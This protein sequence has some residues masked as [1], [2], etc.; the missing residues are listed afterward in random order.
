MIKF[1]WRPLIPGEPDAELIWGSILGV[2]AL[3]AGCWL[4]SGV[5]TPL[6][7]FHTLTGF[8]CP[9]CG[10]TRG[11]RCLLRGDPV[12]AFLFNPL[13]LIV[14]LGL[15]LYLIYALVVITARLPRLR[16][17]KLSPKAGRVLRWSLVLLVLINW[18]Y[19]IYH[20]K[21]IAVLLR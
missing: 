1:H 11:M 10:L 8:P 14:V 3:I 7:T 18:S 12:S 19:L 15:A 9:T 5:P 2:T 13:A 17:G 4:C 21:V 20:E 16:W 6:C